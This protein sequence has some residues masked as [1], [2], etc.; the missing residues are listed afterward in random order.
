MLVISKEEAEALRKE[1]GE[2]AGVA[3]VNRGKRGGRKKYYMTEDPA[4]VI[5]IAKSRGVSPKSLLEG[6][7]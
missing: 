6:N 2:G 7:Y 4:L 5:F 3:I 1:F